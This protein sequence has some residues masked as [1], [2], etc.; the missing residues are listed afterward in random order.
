MQADDLI[1]T[2]CGHGFCSFR[3]ATARTNFCRE[4]HNVMGECRRRYCPLANSVYATIR[5][6]G[7]HVYLYTKSIE[8]AH[9]PNKMWAKLLLDEDYMKALQQVTETLDED[10]YSKFLIHR[11]KQ[12]LTKVYQYLERAK[13]LSKSNDRTLERVNVK[14]DRV[15]KARAEKAERMAKI[16]LVIKDQLLQRLKSGVYGDIYENLQDMML[17]PQAPVDEK[18]IEQELEEE[19]V[20]YEEDMSEDI[21]DWAQNYKEEKDKKDI[22]YPDV[23]GPKINIEY[24]EE[25]A[26]PDENVQD[27][28]QN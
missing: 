6:F 2:N 14:E 11:V 21:E 20:Q 13:Q 25:P 22:E 10:V 4:R 24:E 12:R 16:D 17:N 15:D 9:T 23:K 19:L 7:G 28:T 5:E 1:W 18:Q 3:V 26:E 27:N 8:R